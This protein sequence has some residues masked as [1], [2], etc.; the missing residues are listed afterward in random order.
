MNAMNDFRANALSEA[1]F[2]GHERCLSLLEECEEAANRLGSRE[3]R[4]NRL[5]ASFE[6]IDG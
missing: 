5:N 2:N 6:G 3:S 4:L 1:S